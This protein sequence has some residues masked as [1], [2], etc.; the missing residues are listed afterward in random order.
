[1]WE[2]AEPA[3]AAGHALAVLLHQGDQALRR[4]ALQQEGVLQQV[5]GRGPLQGLP[6]QH[7]I[8][9]VSQNWGDLGGD[10]GMT[11][12]FAAVLSEK[13][14]CVYACHAYYQCILYVS[15]A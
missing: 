5:C 2:G 7:A 12:L 4:A 15:T 14:S 8:Q 3:S 10:T 1:M 6:R 11:C 9:E 13:Q